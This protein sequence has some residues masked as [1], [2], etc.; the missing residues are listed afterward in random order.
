MVFVVDI[1][2]YQNST[3]NKLTHSFKLIA[4]SVKFTSKTE[5][6][7]FSAVCMVVKLVINFRYDC[8][9]Y[10]VTYNTTFCCF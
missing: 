10:K 3:L 5:L 7:K 8:M 6:Y 2:S 1:M 9:F 4:L